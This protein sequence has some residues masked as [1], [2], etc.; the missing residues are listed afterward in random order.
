LWAVLRLTVMRA[1]PRANAMWMPAV[2]W[3]AY[4]AWEWLVLVKSPDANIRVDLLLLW[5]L[6]ALLTLWGWLRTAWGWWSLRRPG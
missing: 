6:V 5:P 2:A 3:L 1:A 4:A